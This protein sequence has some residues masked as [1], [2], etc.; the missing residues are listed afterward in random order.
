VL[1]GKL[2]IIGGENFQGE[3]GGFTH[4]VEAYNPMT[5]TWSN[6][7]SMSVERAALAAGTAM[8]N[9]EARIFAVGGRAGPAL[10]T[11]EMF[12]R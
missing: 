4:G 2:Y 8:L 9:A 12:T 1:G 5:N 10:Q 3:I 11:N 6:P 7:A